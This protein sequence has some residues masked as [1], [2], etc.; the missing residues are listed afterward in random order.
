M[1]IVVTGAT[2]HLGRLA[3]E[4]LLNRGIPASDIIAVGR[5]VDRIADLAARGVDV[6]AADLD[7]P[8][9][10]DRAFSGADRLLLVSS[11]EV[12]RRVPQHRNAVDAAAR[13]GVGFIVY[14]SIANVRGSSMIIAGEHLA[15]EQVIEA[16]GI[17]FA[18]LR[19]SWYLENY[20]AQIPTYLAHGVA[21]AAGS[22]KVSAATRA[23]YAAA[24]AAVVSGSDT[25]SRAYELG[26][27]P[28]TL[29]EL[30]AE[31]AAQAGRSVE[32]HDMPEAAYRDLLVSVG[33]PQPAAAVY[34]DAD[35]GIAA[36]DLFV[37]GADLAN[38]IGRPPTPLAEAVREVLAAVP[39]NA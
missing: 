38:L 8:A 11:S 18:F 26:G 12:G 34:A 2:G 31:I 21:G 3:I 28:F 22:G 39:A 15:T 10:L 9:T 13:V 7:D 4:D 30:A 36:G 5:A 25:S 17:P 20:T 24:A 35:R 37:D 19:N 32:Y 29:H 14:T 27:S 16:S 1:R 33:L 23:D 6:R